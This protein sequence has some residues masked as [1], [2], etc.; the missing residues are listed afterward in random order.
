M[1]T[2]LDLGPFML[3]IPIPTQVRCPHCASPQFIQANDS[4]PFT[5]R[6]SLQPGMLA[7]QALPRP[8]PNGPT[9]PGPQVSQIVSEVCIYVHIHVL[10]LTCN[11]PIIT[12]I[13]LTNRRTLIIIILMKVG[14]KLANVKSMCE[15]FLSCGQW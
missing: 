14:S 11:K 15:V 7:T 10:N 1:D 5:D 12:Q 9:D 6:R 3:P 13:T 4:M 8:P 2:E